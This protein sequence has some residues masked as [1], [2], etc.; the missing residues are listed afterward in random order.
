MVAFASAYL[1]SLA[2]SLVATAA[3]QQPDEATTALP[4]LPEANLKLMWFTPVLVQPLPEQPAF[5]AALAAAATT[6]FDDFAGNATRSGPVDDR[7]PAAQALRLVVCDKDTE[8][9]EACSTDTSDWLDLVEPHH[10]NDAF[11]LWQ[12]LNEREEK[13]GTRIMSNFMEIMGEDGAGSNP[14]AAPR[15]MRRLR[16]YITAA[17]AKL[18]GSTGMQ[19]ATSEASTS[20]VGMD[21]A[22]WTSV[23]QS[24]DGASSQHPSHV[25]SGVSLS[26]VF[27]ASAPGGAGKRLRFEVLCPQQVEFKFS[28]VHALALRLRAPLTGAVAPWGEAAGGPRAQGMGMHLPYPPAPPSSPASRW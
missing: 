1:V 28:C 16:V 18:R 9:F 15:E 24:G 19:P 26:A 17:L 14:Y 2:V 21:L 13:S 3:A 10:V 5:G 20:E 23:H 27:Y 4:A 8:G 22:C 6:A 12:N 7:N 11:Y 25:H